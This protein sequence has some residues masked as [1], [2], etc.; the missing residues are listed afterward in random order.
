MFAFKPI[1]RLTIPL[2][3]LPL[4]LNILCQVG[5]VNGNPSGSRSEIRSKKAFVEEWVFISGKP[6]DGQN[7][8]DVPVLHS[9]DHSD[10][11]PET[12]R[13][14]KQSDSLPWEPTKPQD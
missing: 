11:L 2:L 12:P 9:T 10:C 5:F 8:M 4:L 13:I 3:V 1:H 14:S 7:I 6:S